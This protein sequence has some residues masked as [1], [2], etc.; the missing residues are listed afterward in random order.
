MKKFH[1][2]ISLFLI[3]QISFSQYEI[4]QNIGIQSVLIEIKG[5]GSGSGIYLRD[6]SSLYFATAAHVISDI[7]KSKLFCDSTFLISYRENSEVDRPD[8]LFVSLC[9]AYKS[10]YL[11]IDTLNDAAIIKLGQSTRN[12]D[13]SWAPIKY[14]SHAVRIGRGTKLNPWDIKDIKSFNDLKIGNDVFV[15]GY[16]KSL[17]LQFTFDYNRPLLRKG[18]VA[19]RD[20]KTKKIIIDCPTYPGNS[21]GPVFSI[22]INDSRMKL[23]GFVT[24]FIPLEEHWYNDKY[25]IYNT[26]ISNSGYSVIIPIDFTLALIPKLK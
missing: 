16:P 22:F 12:K 18:I 8:T 9:E 3:S 14:L 26:Q 10:G 6:S 13:S 7:R 25:P 23:I 5:L 19:G 24:A 20:Y 15:I 17:N 2:L 11:V 4:D 21:G 1:L